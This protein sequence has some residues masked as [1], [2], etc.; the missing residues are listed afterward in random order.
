MKKNI[1]A[2]I[3]IAMMMVSIFVVSCS[4]NEPE[5]PEE[6]ILVKIG[7]KATISV[8]E[9]VRRAEFVPRPAYC[10]RN[11]YLEKKIVLNSLIAEKML[12]LEAGPN[13]LLD[14]S[15]QFRY[16]LLGRKEQAMRQW[17]HHKEATAIVSLDSADIKNAYQYAGREVEISHVLLSDTTLIQEALQHYQDKNAFEAFASRATGQSILPQRTVRWEDPEMTP[18]HNALFSDDLEIGQVVPPIKIEDNKYLMIKINGWSDAMALTEVQRQGRLTKVTEKLSTQQA[19]AIWTDR[20]GEIMRGKRMDFND[21]TF[22][23][24]SGL[25]FDIYFH[26]EEEQQNR[27]VEQIWGVERDET[28]ESFYLGDDESFLS[29]SFFTVDG[30]VWTV[31]DFRKELLRHPIVFRERK[32][33]SHEFPGQFRLAIADLIRDHY[34]TEEA[35]KSGYDKVNVV[36]RNSNMWRDRFL[37]LYKTQQYLSMV[38]EKRNFAKN[39]MD[40]IEE[41]LNPYVNELQQKYHK[42][43]ELDFDAFEDI[44]LTSIDLFVK[45]PE[46]PYKYVV[47]MFPTVTTDPFLEYVKDAKFD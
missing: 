35:Y 4:K 29:Q 44:Q 41:T 20:V 23:K 18:V 28:K 47:P 31:D 30:K 37:S 11:T 12:A 7:D 10:R 6:K 46:M 26:D 17:M 36:Q 2:P 14:E 9:F 24:L 34:V 5:Q 40:V 19:S 21:D 13:N 27:F 38:G 33:P 32:M 43:V 42:K 22:E 1:F 15:E 39:Q 16:F 3:I 8:N 45:Q 25:F